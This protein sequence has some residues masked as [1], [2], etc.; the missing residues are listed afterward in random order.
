LSWK[1]DCLEN[2]IL[3]IFH[4]AISSVSF[5]DP[6]KRTHAIKAYRAQTVLFLSNR[7]KLSWHEAFDDRITRLTPFLSSHVINKI[8]LHWRVWC[9]L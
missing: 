3:S 5:R 7:D 4:E 8:K 9:V 2:I 6:V 1:I